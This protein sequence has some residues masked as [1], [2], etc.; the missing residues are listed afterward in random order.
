MISIFSLTIP[1]TIDKR[2]FDTLL[3][4]LP[5]ENREKITRKV[6]ARD[7][8]CSLWSEVLVRTRVCSTLGVRNT[9]LVF[10]KTSLESPCS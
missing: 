10:Q 2:I 7:R 8:L 1:D 3:S 6:F 4:H 5:P 9:A